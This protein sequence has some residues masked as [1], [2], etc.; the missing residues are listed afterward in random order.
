MPIE[1][2]FESIDDAPEFLREHLVE[3]D[4][5]H[6]F[7]AKLETEV[8]GLSSALKKERDNAKAAAK[9]AAELEAKLKGYEGAGD[10]DDDD[11]QGESDDKKKAIDPQWQRKLTAAEKQLQ[12]ERE[13]KA[14]LEKQLNEIRSE[15]N[16]NDFRNKLRSVALQAGVAAEDYE[17]FQD[18]IEAKRM[19]GRDESGQLIVTSD[20]DELVGLS[21]VEALKGPLSKRFAKFYKPIVGAGSGAEANRAAVGNGKVKRSEMDIKQKSEY[22]SK[23]G[24]AA[25]FALPN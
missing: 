6:V 8:N 2:V 4:G 15:Q 24:Q 5:K 7:S 21:V 25:F 14:E 20:S 10:D 17:D 11:D 23:H 18:L 12:R 22:I 16:R 3:K 13:G 1:Q 19:I 9:K